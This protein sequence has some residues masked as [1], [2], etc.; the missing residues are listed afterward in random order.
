MLITQQRLSV[1]WSRIF[2]SGNCVSREAVKLLPGPSEKWAEDKV[3]VSILTPKQRQITNVKFN[4]KRRNYL[5][6]E[7]IGNILRDKSRFK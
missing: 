1:I 5:T 7:F 3:A 2:E 6:L 4:S